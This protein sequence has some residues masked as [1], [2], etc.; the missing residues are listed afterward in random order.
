[1]AGLK[2]ILSRVLAS[3]TPKEALLAMQQLPQKNDEAYR[4]V[5]TTDC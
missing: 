1:M 4:K 2:L 5:L 3:R